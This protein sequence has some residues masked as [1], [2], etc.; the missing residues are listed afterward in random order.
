MIVALFSSMMVTNGLND[1]LY[2]LGH[3][4]LQL[5]GCPFYLYV[6][7]KLMELLFIA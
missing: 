4:F 6:L 7:T 1:L 2:L 3:W 5:G